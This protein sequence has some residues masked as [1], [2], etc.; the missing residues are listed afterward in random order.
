MA[1]KRTEVARKLRTQSTGAEDLLWQQLRARRL[2]G[3]KFRRQMPL[4][5]FVVDFCCNEARVTVEIDGAH[6]VLQSHDDAERTR[7]IEAS[8]FTELRFTNDEV[9]E[10]LD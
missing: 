6:H 7:R 1:E 10:R 5:G 9:K 2:D 3:W 8:E 4:G